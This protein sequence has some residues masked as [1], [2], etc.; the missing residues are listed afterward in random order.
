M[1]K[2]RPRQIPVSEPGDVPVGL[3]AL[4]GLVCAYL[5]DGLVVAQHAERWQH[6]LVAG[7]LESPLSLALIFQFAELLGERR[8]I[9]GVDLRFE[10]AYVKGSVTYR[11]HIPGI[12]GVGGNCCNQRLP[13]V[14]HDRFLAGTFAGAERLKH[15]LF[16]GGNAA[17]GE[18]DDIFAKQ[19]L[20]VDLRAVAIVGRPLGG[21]LPQHVVGNGALPGYVVSVDSGVLDALL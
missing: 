18:H 14:A 1:P 5:I 4:V 2:S 6:L 20:E 11:H 7:A 9:G 16:S 13:Q 10:L 8:R 19:F 12:E 21:E 15:E 17:G 3:I